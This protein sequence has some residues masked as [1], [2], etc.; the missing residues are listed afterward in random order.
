MTP[1]DLKDFGR[2]MLIGWIFCAACCLFWWTV[3]TLAHLWVPSPQV[4]L[5]LSFAGPVGLF[6][7][8]LIAMGCTW[9]IT[10]VGGA[11]WKLLGGKG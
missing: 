9:L 4:L 10:E 6:L 3:A 11:L 8:V 5:A 1:E 2:M 7:I